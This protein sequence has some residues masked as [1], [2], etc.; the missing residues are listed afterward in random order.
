MSPRIAARDGDHDDDVDHGVDAAMAACV[1]LALPLRVT[2]SSPRE[3]PP[4]S[5]L[6]VTAFGM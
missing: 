5:P 3:P 2:A 1:Q 4:A 6:L